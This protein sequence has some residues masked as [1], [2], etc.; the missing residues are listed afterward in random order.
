MVCIGQMLRG[1]V[2]ERLQEGLPTLAE[3]LREAATQ[4]V[5]LK[6]PGTLGM[7]LP[8]VPNGALYRSRPGKRLKPR[9][10]AGS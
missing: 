7:S 9:D 5:A 3:T 1:E 8:N 6:M 2:G 10:V 4:C